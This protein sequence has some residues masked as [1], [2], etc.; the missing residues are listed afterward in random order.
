MITTAEFKKQVGKYL[1]E[2]I[3]ELGFKGS[4]FS[5][6]KNSE[7]FIFTIGIQASQYGEMFCAEFGIQPKTVVSNGFNLHDFK[8]IKYSD[9]E[10]RTRITSNGK[11]DQWWSY[12]DNETENFKTVDEII[13]LIKDRIIPIIE[14]F[15]K[16]PL[17]LNYIKISDFESFYSNIQK[18]IGFN[19]ATTEVR[20]AWVLMK[21]FEN[22][23][24]KKSL[25]FAKY[26]LSKLKD[27]NLFFGR[28]D[29]EKMIEQNN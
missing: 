15:E 9:C 19:I 3:R 1:G 14:N 24:L 22:S 2:S 28:H 25:E 11:G 23:D 6:I 18:K 10:L 7:Y 16:N 20:F 27:D 21:H 17:I 4:G 8:K 26:G 13:D 5:Y 29:F 12:N